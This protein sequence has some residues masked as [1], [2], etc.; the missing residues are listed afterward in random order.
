MPKVLGVV[1]GGLAQLILMNDDEM[2]E[3][4]NLIRRFPICVRRF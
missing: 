1:V 3:V 4:E 2:F